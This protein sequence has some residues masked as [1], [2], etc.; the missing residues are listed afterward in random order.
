M[1]D[2]SEELD[3]KKGSRDSF[4][5][6]FERRGKQLEET[7]GVLNTLNKKVADLKAEVQT[8]KDAYAALKELAM[9]QIK[10]RGSRYNYL[11]F[12]N[13][14][15]QLRLRNP[16]LDISGICL[17]KIVEGRLI[18]DPTDSDPTVKIPRM[19]ENY[20]LKDYESKGDE[21]FPWFKDC[22]VPL[23]GDGDQGA[24]NA[25]VPGDEDGNAHTTEGG[26]NAADRAVETDD[27]A[28]EVAGDAAGDGALA[29]DATEE[30]P[31]AD[32]VEDTLADA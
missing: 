19:S 5:T 23:P 6:G 4:Q 32:T 10:W 13:A 26:D 21:D 7:I 3:L 31:A 18:Q 15:Q 2:L 9:R 14:I 16:N 12:K 17:N 27:A 22:V 30:T 28:N 8:R 25:V 24:A 1:E 11:G 20:A 29:G